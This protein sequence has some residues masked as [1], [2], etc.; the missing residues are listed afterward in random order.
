MEQIPSLA[1]T[2]IPALFFW[3]HCFSAALTSCWHSCGGLD[4]FPGVGVLFYSE[5]LNSTASPHSHTSSCVYGENQQL[6]GPV[7]PESLSGNVSVSLTWL[8]RCVI[9]QIKTR[10]TVLRFSS[11]QNA[12]NNLFTVRGEM[13]KEALPSES[14]LGSS[15]SV[16][17]NF[18]SL[19]RRSKSG[20]FF[21][22][23]FE[24]IEG[25]RVRACVS[26]SVCVCVRALAKGCVCVSTPLSLCRRA[27]LILGASQI[28]TT[29]TKI[30]KYGE[31]HL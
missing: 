30:N 17:L 4:F 2:H 22:P 12:N 8:P 13:A 3:C 28:S 31:W 1:L 29:I 18:F 16:F 19:E 10:S 25:P 6:Q 7:P 27:E 26:V 24:L 9:Q 21:P 15:S 5:E 11:F 20:A 23:S 14:P